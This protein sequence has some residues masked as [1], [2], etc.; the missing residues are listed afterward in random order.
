MP[1]Q[2]SFTRREIYSSLASGIS[3]E[4]TL[5]FGELFINCDAKI[6]TGAEVCLFQRA[7]GEAIEIPIENGLKK[8]LETLTGVLTAYGH[9]VVLETLGLRL[10]TVVYFAERDDVKRSLLGRQGWLQLI[11]LGI[12]DYD[13]ELYL[14]LYDE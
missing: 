11:R 6:D 9:E 4:T 7:I 1:F 14:S 10:Q 8:Q 13:S 12:V 5:R 3:L 2:L